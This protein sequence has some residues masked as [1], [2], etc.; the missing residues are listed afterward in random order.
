MGLK[1]LQNRSTIVDVGRHRECLG[2]IGTSLLAR[3]RGLLVPDGAVLVNTL[4]AKMLDR[5]SLFWDCL[6]L[7]YILGS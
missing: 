3:D 4:C 1:K 7:S 6:M 5:V 2:C